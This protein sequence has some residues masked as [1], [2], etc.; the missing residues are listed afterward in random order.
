MDLGKIIVPII[1]PFTDNGRIYEQGFANL[2]R[3]LQSHGVN[4]IWALGSYGAFPLMTTEERKAAVEVL[5][6]LVKDLGMNMIVQVGSPSLEVSLDLAEHAAQ[7]GADALASVVPFYYASAHYQAPNFLAY[8]EAL[9]NQTGLPLFYYNNPK[10]T[11]FTPSLDFIKRL[12]DLGLVGIKDTTSDFISISEKIDLFAQNRPDGWYLGG[13]TS[14]YLPA[15]M[16]G[17]RGV[18]CGTG[19]AFPDLVVKLDQAIVKGDLAEARR[20]QHLALKVRQAQGRHVGRSVA[21]Y[22][23][24]QARGVD[25]GQ[26]RK[27]WLSMTS[28]QNKEVLKDLDELGVL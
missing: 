25:V 19:V 16:M 18:I 2:L 27:P 8:F 23:L 14:V 15:I 26:C 7:T 17:A 9:I 1:T 24:L 10:T 5:A 6:P 3:F 13:S 28:D 22:E 11:G 21:C 20:L 4:D 12:L